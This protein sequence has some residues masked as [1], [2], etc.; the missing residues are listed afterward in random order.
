MTVVDVLGK[1][2]RLKEGVISL[3]SKNSF[4]NMF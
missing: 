1:T 3:R 4:A 2:K